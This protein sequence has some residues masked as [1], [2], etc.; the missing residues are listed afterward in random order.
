MLLPQQ[1]YSGRILEFLSLVSNYIPSGH[2]R[3]INDLSISAF[4]YAQNKEDMR[5]IIEACIPRNGQY[6]ATMATVWGVCQEAMAYYYELQ[7]L[8]YR[9]T[10]ALK[11]HLLSLPAPIQNIPQAPG[12]GIDHE[13]AVV[14]AVYLLKEKTQ[15]VLDWY[16]PEHLA[17]EVNPRRRRLARDRIPLQPI[18]IWALLGRRNPLEQDSDDEEEWGNMDMQGRP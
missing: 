5:A 8:A 11:R 1:N 15:E 9:E 17:V 18:D 14:E 3:E 7:L 16:F 4:K 6:V 2:N 10:L 12:M 13:L